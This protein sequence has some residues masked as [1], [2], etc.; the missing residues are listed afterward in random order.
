[1][2]RPFYRKA[3]RCWYVKDDRDRFIRLDPDKKKAHDL[4]ER[5]RKLADFR[6]PESTLESIFEAYLADVEP[7]LKPERFANQVYF[8]ES[9]ALHYGP[10]R[11]A[12]GV[13][14]ADVLRWVKADRVIRGKPGCWSLARQ[15]DAGQAVKRALSWAIR[16]SYLPWSDV[17]E[18]EFET[19]RP[20]ETTIDEATHEKLV[21][22]C[23]K[24]DRNKPFQLVLMAMR[25]LGARQISIRE[26]TA[27]HF[28]GLALVFRDHKTGRKTGKPLVIQ[29]D[30]CS[31]TLLR[32]LCHA[33]PEGQLFL[34][35]HGK[36]WTKNAIVLAFRRIRDEAKVEGVSSYSYRHAFA[37]DLLQAGESL[38]TVAALLGHTNPAMVAQVY[39]HLD[40]RSDHLAAA[41]LRTRKRQ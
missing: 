5:M 2:K 12:R 27:K 28:N 22:T 3:L 36:Q 25:L 31:Q 37:T 32:I 14:A 24:D 41:L 18:L 15:R 35:S 38:A 19:P 7:Q 23:R 8:L 39:G 4:W 40:K 6:S 20:R 21:R 11:K 13:A 26:A 16:R 10:T 9:F 1:M 33:R 34:N 17:T 29:C 30:G